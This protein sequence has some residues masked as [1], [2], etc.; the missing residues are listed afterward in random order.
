MQIMKM[1]TSALRSSLD[2][3]R[4]PNFVVEPFEIIR[5]L[6]SR[7]NR[8]HHINLVVRTGCQLGNST[9]LSFF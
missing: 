1:T 8:Y 9:V 4:L 3:V 5:L 6:G 2:L 7:P